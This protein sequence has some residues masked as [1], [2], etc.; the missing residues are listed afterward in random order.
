MTNLSEQAEHVYRVAGWYPGRQVDTDL[1][2]DTLENSGLRMHD[3]AKRFLSEFGGLIVDIKGPGISR[4]LEPFEFDPMAALGEDDRFVEW[5]ELIGRSLF[6]IGEFGHGRFF[7]ALD[8]VGDIYL[9]ADW[10]AHFGPS[11]EA[12]EKLALGTAP[13]AIRDGDSDGD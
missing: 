4:A 2:R 5:G 11:Q 9:V 10:I 13:D 6:P 12:L 3:A 7:L 1:W 8:Q